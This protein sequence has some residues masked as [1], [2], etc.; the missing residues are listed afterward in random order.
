MAKTIVISG[1]SGSIGSGICRFLTDKGFVVIGL[2][3][4]TPNEHEQQYFYNVDL[5]NYALIDEVFGHIYAKFKTVDGVINCAGR[6]HNGL[7]VDPFDEKNNLTSEHFLTAFHDNVIL[8]SNL[9]SAFVKRQSK[10]R[11]PSSIVNISSISAF[12]NRGQ[13]AYSAA[14]GAINALTLTWAQEFSVFK[15]RVNAIAPG[16]FETQSTEDALGV[17]LMNQKKKYSLTQRLGSVNEI[18]MLCQQI[19]LNDYINAQIIR[20]DGGQRAP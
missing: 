9:T 10:T 8:T 2:D 13:S 3:I 19:L 20:L 14:K 17:D 7:F 11:Q 5:S 12:G 18:G 6:I 15:I 1:A 16:Y 4:V